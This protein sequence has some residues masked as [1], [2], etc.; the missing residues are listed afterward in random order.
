MSKPFTLRLAKAGEPP[1]ALF[2]VGTGFTRRTAE[3]PRSTTETLMFLDRA[4]PG[5]MTGL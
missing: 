2:A 4:L 5:R 3:D 1:D